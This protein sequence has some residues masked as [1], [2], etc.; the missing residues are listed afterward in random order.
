MAEDEVPPVEGRRKASPK[1][2]GKPV[3]PGIGGRF[4]M[5]DGQRYRPEQVAHILE[6]T[7]DGR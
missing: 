7:P 4:V 2:I 3:P 5:V 6:K 1:S